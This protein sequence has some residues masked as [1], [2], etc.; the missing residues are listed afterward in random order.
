MYDGVTMAR[1]FG[2]LAGLL[3]ATVFA[4]PA[5][6]ETG[7]RAVEPAAP[8]LR[9]DTIRL[10]GA[11]YVADL[12][13]GGRAELTLDPQLQ[14]STEN[15]LRAFQIPFGAAVVVSIPD[16]RVLALVG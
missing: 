1:T 5:P 6:A 3:A 11:R 8:Q 12:A 14:Q 15:L 13:D 10:D 7:R 16:G 4:A 9:P 2:L